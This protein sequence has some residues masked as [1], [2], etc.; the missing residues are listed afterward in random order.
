MFTLLDRL[1]QKGGIDARIAGHETAS[2]RKY[3][4]FKQLLGH[5]HKALEIINDLENL[6]YSPRPFTFEEVLGRCK[7]LVAMVYEGSFKTCC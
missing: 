5:N 6:L 1:M 4:Y 3:R 7:E 2:Q